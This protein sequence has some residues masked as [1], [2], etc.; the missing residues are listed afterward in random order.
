MASSIAHGLS[1][2]IECY[3]QII[4]KDYLSQSLEPTEEV[5][6]NTAYILDLLA[7]K[8]RKAT[9]FYLGNVARKFP[10]L[11]R[12]TIDEGHELG[13]H[14][15]HHL[16][17]DRLTPDQ[18]RKE[19]GTA[20]E[21]I[22]QA[23]GANVTCHRAP[24][25]SI[26]QGNLWALDVLAEAGLSFD[27]SIFPFRGRRY[28]IEDWPTKPTRLDSGMWEIP[29]STIDTS[30]GRLPCLGGGYFRLLPY[31]YTRYSAR[32]LDRDGKNGV[33]YFHPHEFEPSRA[34]MPAGV[35]GLIGR[36]KM[37]ALQI[38]NLLQSTGRRSMRRK[39]EQ[40]LS[41]YDTCPL[42][43]LLPQEEC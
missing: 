25:F 37:A 3:Y 40:F 28:G 26:K 4:S 38:T 8:N 32:S 24:A 19:L 29:L 34:R 10:A 6:R 14:G 43:A 13:V 42:G 23:A 22:Q 5:E 20:I 39:L 15:D 17:I 30:F 16:Y 33:T 21:S 12:R 27:S 41:T 2:D 1:F 36:R 9:F 11:V 31:A 35:S 7:D 18:F